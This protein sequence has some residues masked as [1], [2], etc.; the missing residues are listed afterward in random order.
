M[1]GFVTLFC[2]LNSRFSYHNCQFICVI[3]Q[4]FLFPRY[5]SKREIH[6][7]ANSVPFGL[8]LGTDRS[9]SSSS[10]AILAP[11]EVLEWDQA[12]KLDLAVTYNQ[13]DASPSSISSH[14]IGWLVGDIQK[15]MEATEK[16]LGQG[17]EMSAIG[18]LVRDNRNGKIQIRAPQGKGYFLIRTPVEK[19]VK[20][21]EEEAKF[22]KWLM[23]VSLSWQKLP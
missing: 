23:L 21:L 4:C 12:D 20:D 3:K 8:V 22:L 11:I 1:V 17:A 6:S 5:S 16:M 7:F 19:L 13:F 15:G 18:E 10:S 2:R 9:S 14:L